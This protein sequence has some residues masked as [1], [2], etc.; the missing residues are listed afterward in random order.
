MAKK[1]AE[2]KRARIRELEKMIAE[3]EAEI[4]GYLEEKVA[5]LP[6]DFVV[7]EKVLD[8]MREHPDRIEK[9]TIIPRIKE[10]YGVEITNEQLSS[11][12]S[13]IKYKGLLEIIGRAVYKLK[14]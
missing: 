7:N 13:A 5:P 14:Q 10:K 6:P 4:N 9:K 1:T 12:I 11:A 3:A 8:V 2:E